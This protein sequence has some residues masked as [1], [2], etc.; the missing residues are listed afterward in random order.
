MGGAIAENYWM[1]AH[2][3]LASTA[4]RGESLAA[5]G[6]QSNVFGGE[7]RAFVSENAK[8]FTGH[9]D[10]EDYPPQF[11]TENENKATEQTNMKNKRFTAL[12]IMLAGV[13]GANADAV[14]DWSAIASTTIVAGG[15]PGPSSVID[16]AVVQAAV[17]D[18]VQA[19][20]K[21]FAPY[22]VEILGATGSPAAAVA[23]ATRDILVNRFPAQAATVD[24]V[25][26]TLATMPALGHCPQYRAVSH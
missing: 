15:R 1:D 21:T 10:E 4:R 19:Y 8:P 12:V 25:G 17:H 18:A 16:F 22:A 20:D 13:L 5:N 23:K 7:V 6:I 11:P 14:L 9:P 2:E 24:A 3:V 26:L